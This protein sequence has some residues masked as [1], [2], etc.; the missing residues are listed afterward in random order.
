MWV[1]PA[2]WGGATVRKGRENAEGCWLRGVAGWGAFVI[3]GVVPM[4]AGEWRRTRW[5]R[6][7]GERPGRR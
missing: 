2:E 3:A 1:D 5:S 4:L 7:K 6:V